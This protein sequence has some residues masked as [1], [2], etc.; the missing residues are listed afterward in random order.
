ML[1]LWNWEPTLTGIHE[2]MNERDPTEPTVFD[3]W[4][5]LHLLSLHIY[6]STL[7]LLNV[8]FP[9]FFFFKL[10]LCESMLLWS[11]KPALMYKYMRKYHNTLEGRSRSKHVGMPLENPTAGNIGLSLWFILIRVVHVI[12]SGG[13]YNTGWVL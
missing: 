6:R 7:W 12:G 9:I 8:R 13:F 4:N 10:K 5:F 1:S 3:M 2:W 11:L